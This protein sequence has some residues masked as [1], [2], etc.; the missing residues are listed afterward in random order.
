MAEKKGDLKVIIIGGVA[1]GPKTGATLARRMPDANI[2]LFQKEENVSYGTCGLPYFASGDIGSFDELTKTSYGVKRDADFFKRSKDFDIVAGAKVIKIDKTKKEVSVE[3]LSSGE[4]SIHTYDKLVIAVGA[5][6]S[7]PPFPVPECNIVR[8]FTRPEDAICFR[9]MAEQGQIGNVTIIGGG[10]IGCEM[11]EAVVSMWGIDATIIE[12]ENQLLPYILDPEMAHL[13]EL[14]MKKQGVT[15][16]TNQSVENIELDIEEKPEIRLGSGDEIISDFVFLC[17][18]VRPEISLA[19]ACGLKIGEFGG[20]TVN[21][22]MQ[23]SDLN[24]FAGGDC[25]ENISQLTKK[26]IYMPMGSLANRHGRVIAEN[27]AGNKVKFPGVLGTFLVKVFDTNVGAVG[28]TE[29]A[30]ISANFKVDTVLGS[31]PDIPDFYPEGGTFTLKMV[32]EK[33]TEKLLGLQAVGNG[34]ICRRID[35]FSALLQKKATLNDLLDFEHGYA[36]PYSEAVDSLH[37]MAGMAK[38][39]E[40]GFCFAK[41]EETK[42]LDITWLD[43]REAHE[44]ES[45]PWPHVLDGYNQVLVNIPLNDLKERLNELDPQNKIMVICRRGPRSYQA[46]V[47]LKNAGYKNVYIIGGGTK[48][49]QP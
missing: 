7:P 3:L 13:V 20:I 9:K 48:V 39:K 46:S 4:V 1:T 47:I 15:L 38:A 6:P 18:G 11:A 28:L 49:I 29:K 41:A 17:L 42:E 14:E 2:T 33:K 24:I 30:A 27:I 23:T 37:H 36:P 21:K 43:V 26:P 25:I 8:S 35:T 12:K 32:Y 19:K 40:A 31:F 10:F 22:S 44:V 5:N 34:D 16:L 45:S